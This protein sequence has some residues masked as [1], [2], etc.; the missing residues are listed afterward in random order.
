MAAVSSIGGLSFEVKTIASLPP[1]A[2]WMILIEDSYTPYNGWEFSP[3]GSV[4]ESQPYVRIF[5]FTAFASWTDAVS[6]LAKTGAA[7]GK[8]WRAI[9]FEPTKVEISVKIG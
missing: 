6:L 9:T 7:H 4:S 5:A 3:G 2:R 1:E 8:K